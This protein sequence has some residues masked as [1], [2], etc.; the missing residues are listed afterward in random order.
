MQGLLGT[1]GNPLMWIGAAVV[2]IYAMIRFHALAVP[3]ADTHLALNA[4]AYTSIARFFVTAAGYVLTMIVFYLVLIGLAEFAARDDDLRGFLKDAAGLDV[5]ETA[6]AI[7]AATILSIALPSI[8]ALQ[9]LDKRVRMLLQYWAGIPSMADELADMMHRAG[10]EIR[11]ASESYRKI[12]D[13]HF[14]DRTALAQAFH[15]KGS[16]AHRYLKLVYL[17]EELDEWARRNA[18]F[19]AFRREHPLINENVIGSVKGLR[20]H[21]QHAVAASEADGDRFLHEKVSNAEAGLYRFISHALLSCEKSGS[22]C[23]ERLIDFGFEIDHDY[24]RFDV[25]LPAT[26]FVV[27][28]V[29]VVP[30]V[31]IFWLELSDSASDSYEQALTHL[32][33]VVVFSVFVAFAHALAISLA[34]W[35]RY[36]I[37]GGAGGKHSPMRPRELLTEGSLGYV[38]GVVVVALLADVYDF[39]TDW[40]QSGLV[41]GIPTCAAALSFAWLTHVPEGATDRRGIDGLV[42]A[43]VTGAGALAAAWLEIGL[44][45]TA[46]RTVLG[47]AKS[48]VAAIASSGVPKLLFIAAVSGAL[49]GGVIGFLLP[50][51]YRLKHGAATSSR[52]AVAIIGAG[53]SGLACAA[54]LKRNGFDVRVYEKQG[55]LGGRVFS[56]RVNGRQF[57]QGTQYFLVRYGEFQDQVDQWQRHRHVCSW[58]AKEVAVKMPATSP[59]TV[60]APICARESERTLTAYVGLPSMKDLTRHLADDVTVVPHEDVGSPVYEQ[61]CWLLRNTRG[62]YL[63]RFDYLVLAMP[64]PDAAAL[65]AGGQSGPTPGTPQGTVTQPSAAGGGSEGDPAHL[66]RQGL[67]SIRMTPRIMLFLGFDGPLDLEHDIVHFND[68]CIELAVCDSSKPGRDD[69]RGDNWVVQATAEWS[70]NNFDADEGT[71]E[72][73]LE[74]RFSELMSTLPGFTPRRVVVRDSR[75][76]ANARV[77]NAADE[78]CLFDKAHSI[79]ACGDWCLG[80]YLAAAWVSGVCMANSIDEHDSGVVRSSTRPTRLIDAA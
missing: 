22:A 21:V 34:I 38:S 3:I 40:W 2:T 80:S 8:P 72:K 48:D 14:D 61:D 16:L 28:L 42:Q 55:D 76:W 18:A 29:L 11:R 15:D 78:P 54:T 66:I 36:H 69:S 26:V 4:R 65:L 33:Q 58:D 70:T 47:V 53:V 44:D 75:K 60:G 27:T 24:S 50:S 10:F 45:A 49:I 79:G 43:V 7:W 30:V 77:S 6:P 19:A 23:V 37:F 13:K 46:A 20:W 17:L 63:G 9:N 12:A 64:A 71:I 31:S 68:G 74:D 35:A 41:W 56:G 59:A 5:P 25:A 51:R 32:G 67:E 39:E 73:A 1:L 57:D 52:A 62:H